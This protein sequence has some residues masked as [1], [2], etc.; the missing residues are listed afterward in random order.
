MSRLLSGLLAAS[1]VATV[2]LSAQ[3]EQDPPRP[4][5]GAAGASS[6]QA[7]PRQSQTDATKSITVSGCI[8]SAPAASPAAGAR[9]T[10]P[11]ES[12]RKFVL[13]TKPAAGTP[14]GAPAREGAVG[15]SGSTGLR[16]QLDGDD[17]TI[18]PHLNHQVEITGTLVA[19]A[20]SSGAAAGAAAPGGATSTSPASPMLKVESLKMVAATCS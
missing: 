14:A 12:E 19:P 3:Q 10:A 16:Y 18:S 15:T 17:K 4:S 1:L 9:A 5:G 7:A 13:A 2:G 11:A 20:P 8:Q 6:E